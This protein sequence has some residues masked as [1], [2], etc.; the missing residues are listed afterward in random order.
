MGNFF[1]NIFGK[2]EEPEP[3][4]TFWQYLKGP[5]HSFELHL[6]PT[7]VMLK[8]YTDPAKEPNVWRSTLEDFLAGKLHD[9]ITASMNAG[10][11]P[12]ALESAKK[13][14]TKG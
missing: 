14:G 9:E 13:I 11:L 4:R 5:W 1:K 8:E 7:E 12:E 3:P 6:S 10:V 2:A